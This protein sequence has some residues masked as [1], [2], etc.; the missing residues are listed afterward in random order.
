MAR[1]PQT[2]NGVL[3]V[4]T[5][6]T[7]GNRVTK[8]TSDWGCPC[9]W[10][11][12]SEKHEGVELVDISGSGVLFAIDADNPVILV[13][14]SHGK[15]TEE[16]FITTASGEIPNTQVYVDGVPKSD[17][18]PHMGYGECCVDYV[19]GHVNFTETQSG[20]VTMDYFEVTDSEWVL[21]PTPGK[22]LKLVNVEAQFELKSR[23]KD[24][25]IFQAYGY[26]DVFAPH[27]AVSNGGPIPNGTKIP[28]G[29]P[30][31]Y[32]TR[33]DFINEANGAIPI[34]PRTPVPDEELT[35]RDLRD[36]VITHPWNYQAVTKLSS[37]VGMEIR[38][39][40]EH[41]EPFEGSATAT[42]Y[43]LSYDE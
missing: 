23:V 41:D 10:Y 2:D 28:L 39:K 7:E 35:W 6:P 38:I 22:V 32:K 9:T 26:V 15:Y 16:D 1:V 20:V 43:C 4:S 11:W 40:L 14:N 8:I 25:V 19:N 12:N 18:D 30:T 3:R 31:V 37:A 33:M 34:I 5:E 17:C 24:T 13:D 21:A 42:F 29:N 36:D 27:L